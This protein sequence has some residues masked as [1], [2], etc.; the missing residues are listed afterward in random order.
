MALDPVK[1]CPQCGFSVYS[2]P[3][4]GE[5]F[6]W[7]RRTYRHGTADEHTVRRPQS[8]CKACQAAAVKARRVKKKGGD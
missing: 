7:R 1:T 8:W 2:E 5:Y 4:V 3:A 6:G